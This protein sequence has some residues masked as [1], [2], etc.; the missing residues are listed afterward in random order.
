MSSV[1]LPIICLSLYNLSTTQHEVR[2][3]N[4]TQQC[5]LLRWSF[6]DS[7]GFFPIY[8]FSLFFFFKYFV[9]LLIL[10]RSL[11]DL[12]SS[13]HWCFFMLIPSAF[14]SQNNG[15]W[16]LK[17]MQNS[18]CLRIHALNFPPPAPLLKVPPT[19]PPTWPV[20]LGVYVFPW[21]LLCWSLGS[22]KIPEKEQDY[23]PLKA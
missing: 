15:T 20:H 8:I 10:Q 23:E 22:R 4:N 11:Q 1:Y 12:V 17:G 2:I 19:D 14:V 21:H 7:N 6:W 13:S 16:I 18:I 5:S 9:V 3:R